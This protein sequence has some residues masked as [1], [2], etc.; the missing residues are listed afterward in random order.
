MGSKKEG[1]NH[2]GQFTFTS[3]DLKVTRLLKK[4]ETGRPVA[5]CQGEKNQ[6]TSRGRKSL[7]V[8]VRSHRVPEWPEEE[9]KKKTLE[10]FSMCVCV[11]W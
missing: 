11:S 3:V 10:A 5:Q 1:R 2:F 8:K 7:K 6:K 9:G 4:K